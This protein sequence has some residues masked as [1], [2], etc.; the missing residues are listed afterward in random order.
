[1]LED[2]VPHCILTV[3]D[4]RTPL[5]NREEVTFHREQIAALKALE[6]DSIQHFAHLVNTI[7]DKLKPYL[8]ESFKLETRQSEIWLYQL[9]GSENELKIKSQVKVVESISVKAFVGKVENR[10][11]VQKVLKNKKLRLFSQLEE[12]LKSLMDFVCP[13]SP[14]DV[15]L[16]CVR[17]L[18]NISY[19]QDDYD[20]QE[21]KFRRRLELITDQLQL[22]VSKQPRYG[23]ATKLFAFTIFFT[24]R[25][26]YNVLRESFLFPHPD[27]LRHLTSSMQVLDNDKY[28][29]NTVAHLNELDKLVVLQFD[30]MYI[31]KKFEYRQD[32]IHGYCENRN[33]NNG[34]AQSVLGI[35]ISSMCTKYREVVRL[36]PVAHLSA[37]EL[38]KYLNQALEFIQKK[39]G[40]VVGVLSADDHRMNQKVFK[41]FS[42]NFE[43][44]EVSFKNPQNEN[45]KIF[46]K[47]D[48][49]HIVKNVRNNLMT[50][51]TFTVPSFQP[52]LNQPNT[53]IRWQCLE[54]SIIKLLF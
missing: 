45:L 27:Y 53:V 28:F 33:G 10:L 12:I 31:D 50:K 49:V 16:Q 11:I 46:L 5:R 54:V 3:A 6:Q 44:G 21:E 32:G 8:S 47:F 4:L 22:L 34:L 2:A 24:N 9:D 51:G 30:E 38:F 15:I 52:D 43:Q 41:M 36:I 37:E 40:F 18:S 35:M 25:N 42:P 13:A 7:S 20:E 19:S 1:M 23:L 29:N 17:Q 14:N 39:N 48:V 26:A